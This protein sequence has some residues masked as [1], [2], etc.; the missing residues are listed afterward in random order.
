M[1]NGD[2]FLD[3]HM[4]RRRV[5]DQ[6]RPVLYAVNK[7]GGQKNNTLLG[8]RIG[9]RILSTEDVSQCGNLVIDRSQ[10]EV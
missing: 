2:T 5:I 6:R 3:G 8:E 9:H 1:A 7:Q 4:K 10:T